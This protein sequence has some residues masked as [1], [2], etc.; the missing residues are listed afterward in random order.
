MLVD[1]GVLVGVFVLVAVRVLVEVG[2]LVRVGVLVGVGVTVRVVVGVRVGVGVVGSAQAWVPLSVRVPGVTQS[3]VVAV[4]LDDE[5]A[6]LA[7]G[8]SDAQNA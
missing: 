5:G 3:S 8:G 4:A 6:G 7:V 2:V 1:V